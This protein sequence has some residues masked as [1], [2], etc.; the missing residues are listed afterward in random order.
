MVTYVALIGREVKICI[1]ERCSEKELQLVVG[2]V[3]TVCEFDLW[4]Y[5]K[6]AVEFI[7]EYREEIIRGLKKG[8]NKF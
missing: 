3:S 7:L 8:W 4:G 5:V 6:K 2:G 1:M